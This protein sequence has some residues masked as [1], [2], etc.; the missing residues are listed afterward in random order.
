MATETATIFR[1]CAVGTP[2]V[3]TTKVS[4]KP[5]IAVFAIPMN[6][7]PVKDGGPTLMNIPGLVLGLGRPKD[8]RRPIY[9]L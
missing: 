2:L 1:T 5:F 7:S 9:L 8:I 4:A 6:A 3:P